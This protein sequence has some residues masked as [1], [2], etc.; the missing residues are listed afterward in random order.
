MIGNTHLKDL[1][2]DD[3]GQ[4]YD[5]SSAYTDFRTPEER[6]L[7]CSSF[8][9][10][11]DSASL[12]SEI[13]EGQANLTLNL[14]GFADRSWETYFAVCLGIVLQCG[15]LVYCAITA[16]YWDLGPRY[17]Y[18]CFVTGTMFIICGLLACGH[19]IESV[20]TEHEFRINPSEERQVNL[21]EVI[22]I[23]KAAHVG[24]EYFDGYSLRTPIDGDVVLRTSRPNR[25]EYRY[26]PR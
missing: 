12:L 21:K 26:V 2:I 5:L 10:D 19:V 23:Q 3:N 14:R 4:V 18:P 15:D 9:L 17:A 7:V 16:Y 13:S 6:P 1:L 8:Q 22:R 24:D 25:K 20:T 11:Y